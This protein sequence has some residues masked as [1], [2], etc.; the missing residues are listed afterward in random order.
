MDPVTHALAGVAIR[1]LGFKRK[2]AL[3]VAL[4]SA[5]APDFDYI[6]R[7]WGADVF[8][9]YHRGI[10]HGFPAL[11][12]FALLMGLI[13]GL[14]K[15]FFYY[16]SL[17]ALAYGLHLA[18]DLMNQYST[19]VMSPLDWRQFSFDTA[20]IIDP[21]ITLGLLIGVA[22]SLANKKRAVFA[23]SMTLIL[24]SLYLGGRY[25]LHERAEDFLKGKMSDS[26]CKVT[27]LPNDFLRWWFLASSAEGIKT[28]FVDLFTG[29][30]CV[31]DSYPQPAKDELIEKS[32]EDKVIKN[33][34]YFARY[35][36]PSVER[37][38]GGAIVTW[39]ELSF[40][41]MAE[42]RFVAKAH[43]TEDGKVLRSYFK[44]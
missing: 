13:F 3:W 8:L 2:A 30:V 43:M 31:Q 21:Y 6:S 26:V 34:L 10:T 37:S 22:V 36:Y 42:E 38:G 11:I 24:L 41:F 12:A 27:P 28:G 1:N 15:G 23:A 18:L 35:P 14:K 25:Y 5:I 17:S 32:K 44:F 16:F 29:R 19:R 9:R 4:I 33:F 40:S 20:F 39:K 7:F